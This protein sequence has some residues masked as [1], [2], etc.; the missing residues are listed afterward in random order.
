[1]IY[2]PYLRDAKGQEC[3]VKN[4]NKKKGKEDDLVAVVDCLL[5]T[6]SKI[7]QGGIQISKDTVLFVENSR[8]D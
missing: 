5:V 3:A 8:I 2:F 6:K 1:M 7:Y 4:K